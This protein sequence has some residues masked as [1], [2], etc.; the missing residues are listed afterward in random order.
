MVTLALDAT[1]QNAGKIANATLASQDSQTGFT[2]FI[3]GV[4]NGTTLP[5]RLYTY[6]NKGSCQQP[7]PVAFAMND[8][9]ET[10]PM[11]N[12]RAWT[13]SRSAPMKM[14]GLLSGGYSIV[15]KTTPADGNLD[16][17]C[18]NIQASAVVTELRLFQSWL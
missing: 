13:F 10:E 9:I 16:I 11:A 17:F 15:V 5:L 1:A 7:G 2:F 8:R 3:G 4:P 14:S 18:G 12:A 6:I